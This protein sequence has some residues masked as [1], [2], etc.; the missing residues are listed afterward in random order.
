MNLMVNNNLE[1]FVTR[2]RV[3]VVAALIVIVA[4]VIS[5]SQGDIINRDGILY[6]RAAAV[7]LDGG[8]QAA[9]SVYTWPAYSIII[10]EISRYTG[11]GLEFS[12]WLLNGLCL[13]LLTDSFIRLAHMLDERGKPWVPMLILFSLPVIRHRLEIIRDWGYLAF[14]LR[15]FVSLLRFWLE[16]RGSLRNV[17]NWFMFMVVAFFFRI[18]AAGI[19][20]LAAPVCLLRPRPWL[21]RIRGGGMIIGV[22]LVPCILLAVFIGV[23][24]ISMFGRVAELFFYADLA[25]HFSG[26][27]RYASAFA[28]NVLNKYSDDAA[29]FM[30]GVG[31]VAMGFKMILSNLG[32]MLLVLLAATWRELKGFGEDYRFVIGFLGVVILI[33]CDFLFNHIITVNRYALLGSLLLMLFISYGVSRLYDQ[34]SCVGFWGLWRARVVLLGLVV[35]VLINVSARPDAKEYLRE[36][37]V[38]LGRSVP[39]SVDVVVNDTRLLYYSGRE[40]KPALDTDV[41][42]KLKENLRN[43]PLPYYVALKVDDRDLTRFKSIFG[44]EPIKVFASKRAAEHAEVYYITATN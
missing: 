33:L 10:A 22:W 26:F 14:C 31:I 20:L 11:W 12:A 23:H 40:I 3:R 36:A 9:M 2:G 27:N 8:I 30:L 16:D 18:E 7:Y 13:F 39:A 1:L 32:A 29:A 42:D 5:I 15:A 17:V 43:I 41:L 24:N 28:V 4:M 38:W 34:A 44:V 35:V 21:E 6:L 25:S 37:G 19:V